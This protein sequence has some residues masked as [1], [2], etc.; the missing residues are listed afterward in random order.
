MEGQMKHW[1]LNQILMCSVTPVYQGFAHLTSEQALAKSGEGARNV[2]GTADR[3][4][5]SSSEAPE[6]CKNAQFIFNTEHQITGFEVV[7]SREDDLDF[8]EVL[9]RA[10]QFNISGGKYTDRNQVYVLAQSK[11][12]KLRIQFDVEGHR[13][14]LSKVSFLYQ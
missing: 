10:D 6:F 4:Q 13:S 2:S 1:G 8:G 3:L 7:A 11:D 14:L 5:L 12:K 9:A